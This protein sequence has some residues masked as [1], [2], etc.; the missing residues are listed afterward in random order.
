MQRPVAVHVVLLASTID[1]RES[2]KTYLEHMLQLLRLAC[3]YI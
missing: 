3:Q 2:K 1:V